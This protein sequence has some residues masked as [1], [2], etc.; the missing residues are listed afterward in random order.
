MAHGKSLELKKIPPCTPTW[1][2]P[3]GFNERKD[4]HDRAKARKLIEKTRREQTTARIAE[5]LRYQ[6]ILDTIQPLTP[7]VAPVVEEVE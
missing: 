2:Q 5:G 7:V 3:M 4:G 6:A 1:V